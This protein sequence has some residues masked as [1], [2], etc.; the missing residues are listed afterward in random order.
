M[1]IS[2]SPPGSD[3]PAALNVPICTSASSEGRSCSAIVAVMDTLPLVGAPAL[4]VACTL[5]VPVKESAPP[6]VFAA[7]CT[8]SSGLDDAAA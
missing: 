6:V 3:W 2:E 7:S 4:A 8:A 5:I 1:T